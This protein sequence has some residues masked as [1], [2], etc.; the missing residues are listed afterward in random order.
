MKATW[1]PAWNLENREPQFVN[2]TNDGILMCIFGNQKYL[3]GNV[4]AIDVVNHLQNE[5]KDL[6]ETFNFLFAGMYTIFQLM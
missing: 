2:T 6:P 5:G 3:W 1:K 4:P